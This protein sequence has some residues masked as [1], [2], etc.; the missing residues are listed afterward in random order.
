MALV[1]SNVLAYL[2]VDV[3]TQKSLLVL[4]SCKSMSHR[5]N[6]KYCFS[7]FTLLLIQIITFDQHYKRV[8]HIN[9]KERDLIFNFSALINVI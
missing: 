5:I 6:F 1:P 3:N 7:A 4:F 8:H 9:Q 2:Y